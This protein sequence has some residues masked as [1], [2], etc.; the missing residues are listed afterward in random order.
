MPVK[1]LADAPTDLGGAEATPVR[2][3]CQMDR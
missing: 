1:F 2:E 3:T